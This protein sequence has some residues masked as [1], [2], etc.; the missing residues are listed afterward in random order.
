MKKL[1]LILYGAGVLSSS[2]KYS[3]V[4]SAV[5]ARPISSLFPPNALLIYQQ[6]AVVITASPRHDGD[7]RCIRKYEKKFISSSSSSLAPELLMFGFSFFF[8]I[9]IFHF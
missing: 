2:R 3:T 1:D 8:S 5:C 6:Q 7:G 9:I 4:D